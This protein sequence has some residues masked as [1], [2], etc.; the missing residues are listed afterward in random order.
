MKKPALLPIFE[1]NYIFAIPVGDP[2][3]GGERD[4]V[5]VD[6]GDGQAALEW[7]AREEWTPH[8]I[9]LTHHHDDHIGGV[10]LIL[11]EYPVPV[12]GP[13][14]NAEQI[15]DMT[16][17]VN[18][19]DIL[20][21]AGVTLQVLD[22][23]GHTLGHVAYWD[24]KNRRLFSG[25]VL[26]GLGCGRLFEGTPETMFESLSKIKALPDSTEIYCTHEYT[27]SNLKFCLETD[28]EPKRYDDFAKK[29]AELRARG[30]PSVPLSLA[31]EKK[32]NPFLLATTAEDFRAKREARNQFR[33]NM[34]PMT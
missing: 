6:P 19:G 14:K 29:L 8:G 23:P 2:R 21:F 27:E 9:L 11:E 18:E 12:W 7:I 28:P 4:V 24:E 34:S 22:L 3:R 32:L 10:P 15:P 30:E 31:T 26:F 13:M 5:L 17:P 1:D 33:P 16:D 20:K 25:D